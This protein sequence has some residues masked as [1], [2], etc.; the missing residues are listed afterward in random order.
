VTRLK[1][2]LIRLD[3]PSPARLGEWLTSAELLYAHYV[4]RGRL[5][6]AREVLR[7]VATVPR[8]QSLVKRQRYDSIDLQ[9][10]LHLALWDGDVATAERIVA[11]IPKQSFIRGS[12]LWIGTDAAIMLARGDARG[13]L[14]RAQEAQRK[15]ARFADLLGVI[16]LEQRWWTSLVARA[17][18]EIAGVAPLEETAISWTVGDPASPV[19]WFALVPVTD[20]PEPVAGWPQTTQPETARWLG[21]GRV[22]AEPVGHQADPAPFPVPAIIGARPEATVRRPVVV[23]PKEP[24]PMALLKAAGATAALAVAWLLS[25]IAFTVIWFPFISKEEDVPIAMIAGLSLGFVIQLG[26]AI[27]IWRQAGWVWGV[28]SLLVLILVF[29]LYVYNQ[30]RGMVRWPAGKPV[31]KFRTA[32]TAG[33]LILTSVFLLGFVAGFAYYRH[34]TAPDLEST[35]S[36]QVR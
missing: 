2:T 24:V 32:L 9:T 11:A 36:T 15:L 29:P 1:E 18:G 33:S 26:I 4:D 22:V 5:D 6:E 17:E 3:A 34:V 21:R 28:A 35:R 30:N 14:K 7:R 31:R 12:T 10:A 8:E 27:W 16:A 20:V 25:V 23:V 13:A 19:E